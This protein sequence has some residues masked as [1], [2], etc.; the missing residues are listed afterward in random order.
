[1]TRSEG[2]LHGTVGARLNATGSRYTGQRRTVVEILSRRGTPLTIAE[3]LRGRPELKQSSVYRNLAAMEAAGVVSRVSTDEEYGRYEL[4][5]DITGHHH[6]LICLSCGRIDEVD[7]PPGLERSLDRA[8][9]A[10]ADRAGFASVS[11]RLDL[12]GRC[13]ACA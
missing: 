9:D 8:I 10:L 6:H 13:A 2:D 4:A 7:L 12:I 3:I 1:M 5:E 11:H